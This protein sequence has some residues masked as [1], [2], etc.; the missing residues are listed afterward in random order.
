MLFYLLYFNILKIVNT[1]KN[2]KQI[3]RILMGF[4]LR[5]YIGCRF[6]MNFKV[7]KYKI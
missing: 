1:K 6:I 4:T 5:C 2:R 3:P 7:Y